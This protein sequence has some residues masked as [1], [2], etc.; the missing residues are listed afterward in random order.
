MRYD[1]DMTETDRDIDL[2]GQTER[3]TDGGYVYGNWR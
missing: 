3:Q 1:M 2:Q